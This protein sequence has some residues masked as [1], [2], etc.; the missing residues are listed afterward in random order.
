MKHL[1]KKYS[2][3]RSTIIGHVQVNDSGISVIAKDNVIRTLVNGCDVFN[4]PMNNNYIDIVAPVLADIVILLKKAEDKTKVLIN[5]E[6]WNTDDEFQAKELLNRTIGY[7]SPQIDE[8]SLV[9]KKKIPGERNLNQFLS[10]T[11]SIST[12]ITYD[13]LRQNLEKMCKKLRGVSAVLQEGIDSGMMLTRKKLVNTMW[14]AKPTQ[15]FLDKSRL[16]LSENIEKNGKLD[17]LCD[18]IEKGLM[19][20]G[21]KT[22]DLSKLENKKYI[23]NIIVPDIIN[24]YESIKDIVIKGV[25]A[26]TP[27]VY[28]DEIFQKNT[29]FPS[30]WFVSD[31]LMENIKNTYES[32]IA[33]LA[34]IPKIESRVIYPLDFYKHQISQS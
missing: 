32:L 27:L 29:S 25:G 19:Q 1:I 31:E 6:D 18:L 34:T 20:L 11:S 7:V 28:I 9:I 15:L 2:L 8:N 23:C 26:L 22:K 21:N 5:T 10:P 17:F 14:G 33:F 30:N 3:N 4:V 12:P 16:K 24:N 13:V